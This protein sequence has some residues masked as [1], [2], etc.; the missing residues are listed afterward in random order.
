ML[1]FQYVGGGC[2]VKDVAYF[3]GSCLDEDSCEA[4]EEALLDSYFTSLKDA[5]ERCRPGTDSDAVIAE[6]RDL[7]PVAW[8]DFHRFLKGWCPG[9]WKINSYSERVA[10]EV[11]ATI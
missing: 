3:I 2:G 11:L 1:D 10:R 9:H 8:T 6:W 4:Q 5:L 7:F